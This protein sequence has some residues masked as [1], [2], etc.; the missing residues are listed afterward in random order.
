MSRPIAITQGIAFAFPDV[1]L[2]V[3][4]PST[5]PIPYPNVA[6]L[7]QAQDVATDLLVGS[8]RLPALLVDSSVPTSTGTPP[9]AT[10]GAVSGK[11]VMGPCKMIQGSSSVVYGPDSR[12]LVR[13]GDPT[14]QND[15]NSQGVVLGAFP[16]VLVGD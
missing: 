16:T 2:T 9:N 11:P 15:G 1:C 6:Q 13:F 12:G 8:S 5:V 3:V 7:A 4:G 10:Q 14:Q